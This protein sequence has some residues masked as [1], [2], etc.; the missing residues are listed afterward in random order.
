MKSVSFASKNQVF[1]VEPIGNH[2]SS[3]GLFYSQEELQDIEE[4][5]LWIAKEVTNG[6]QSMIIDEEEHSVRGLEL[7]IP[8]IACT[9]CEIDDEA[10]EAVMA[11]QDNQDR[12]DV[13]DPDAIVAAYQKHGAKLSQLQARKVGISD[14]VTAME[15]Y[16]Q[17]DEDKS[18]RA[19]KGVPKVAS[20]NSFAVS[21]KITKDNRNL[22]KF[23]AKAA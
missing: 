17:Y 2:L 5:N 11:E 9:R 1:L 22:R 6:N 14:Y 23:G 10:F 19:L 18:C 12:R 8:S 20:I 7:E 21:S 15:S 4:E 3:M 16:N 13:F